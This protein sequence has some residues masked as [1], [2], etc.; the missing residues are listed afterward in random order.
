MAKFYG[1][2]TVESFRRQMKES[3]KIEEL[4]LKFASYAT[5]VLKKEPSLAGEGW[6]LELNNQIAQFIKLLRE[7]LRNVHHVSPELLSRLDTYTAKLA[8]ALAAQSS[9][10]QSDSGY[11]SSSTTRDQQH[12]P[13]PS[14]SWSIHDMPMVKIVAKLFKIPDS[15]MQ[16]EVDR[17]RGQAVNEKVRPVLSVFGV[18]DHPL[19][20]PHRSQDLSQEHQRWVPVPWSTRRLLL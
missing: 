14:I 17:I 11:E 18:A 15:S 2:F 10:A 1:E 13:G 8:P 6:K 16:A 20:S 12:H 9:Y 7:C 5:Q 4:I 19:G 3:R